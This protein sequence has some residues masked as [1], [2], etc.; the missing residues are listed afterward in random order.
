MITFWKYQKSGTEKPPPILT[1]TT[2]EDF[3]NGK[4][5]IRYNDK[6]DDLLL[7]GIYR[8]DGWAFDFTPWLK[9]YRV[10]VNGAWLS[11]LYWAP[12]EKELQL[13][14]VH[15]IEETEEVEKNQWEN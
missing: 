4:Y 15:S 14:F 7:A 6:V 8:E 3:L 12:S 9:R 13:A 2:P 1:N 5:N 10:N 11:Y